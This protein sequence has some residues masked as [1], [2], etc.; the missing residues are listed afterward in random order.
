MGKKE[1][2]PPENNENTNDGKPKNPDGKFKETAFKIMT[3]LVYLGG[4]GGTGFLASLY[5]I[6]FWVPEV[7]NKGFLKAD[8]LQADP[9]IMEAEHF[10]NYPPKTIASKKQTPFIPP[11]PAIAIKRD[12][13]EILTREILSAIRAN[14]S[15]LEGEVN[16]IVINCVVTLKDFLVLR[17]I[18][19]TFFIKLLLV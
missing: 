1:K 8:G 2:Q 4:V 15:K 7:P 14:Y 6:I 11:P 9:Y 17:Y 16:V 13:T 3:I 5:Y 18:F 19:D 12:H 10:K